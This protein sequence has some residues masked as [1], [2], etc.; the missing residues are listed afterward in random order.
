MF[1][2]AENAKVPATTP[3]PA[4]VLF[5]V[6]NCG[7]VMMP[8]TRGLISSLVGRGDQG[9]ALGLVAN[10]EA[11]AATTAPVI[12]GYCYR[13]T[14]A[15]MPG[16]TFFVVGGTVGVAL[17]LSLGLRAPRAAACAEGLHGW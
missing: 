14:V 2:S 11:L 9:K 16:F 4:F 12:W 7:M 15:W 17:L 1:G 3:T 6:A 5:A 13:S 8:A 10:V